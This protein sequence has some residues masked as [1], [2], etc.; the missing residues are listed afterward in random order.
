MAACVNINYYRFE[1]LTSRVI[2]SV[3]CLTRAKVN[4]ELVQYRMSPR[5]ITTWNF[6][7]RTNDSRL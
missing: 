4:S 3:K 2:E 7:H 1:V 6:R 5:E